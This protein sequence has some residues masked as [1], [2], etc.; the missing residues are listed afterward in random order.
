M[1]A[2]LEEGD[3]EVAGCASCQ[4]PKRYQLEPRKGR[5]DQ[6]AHLNRTIRGSHSKH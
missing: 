3:R 4:M 1:C 5:M 6:Y 2:A